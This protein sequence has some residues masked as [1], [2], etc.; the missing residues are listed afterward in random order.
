MLK[1][2]NNEA[3]RFQTFVANRISA[4]REMSSSAQWRHI[5]T[6]DNPADAASRGKK[7]S[8]F[9]KKSKLVEGTQFSLEV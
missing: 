2:I 6:K 3:R 1:C 4:I 9:L 5:G 8:D 7:V